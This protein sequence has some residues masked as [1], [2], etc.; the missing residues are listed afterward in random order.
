MTDNNQKQPKPLVV[1]H[2][3]LATDQNLRTLQRAGYAVIVGEDPT[4]IAMVQVDTVGMAA[5]SVPMVTKAAL[6]TL[7]ALPHYSN[8]HWVLFGKKMVKALL[9]LH[10]EATN[11]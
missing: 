9:D 5:G 6:E 7:N 8:D 4:L 1:V 10:S 2:P 11:G 3:A